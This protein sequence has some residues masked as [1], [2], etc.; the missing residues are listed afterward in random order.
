MSLKTN[1]QNS[2]SF[3]K[4]CVFFVT[5]TI[6]FLA[7]KLELPQMDVHD[8]LQLRERRDLEKSKDKESVNVFS[9]DIVS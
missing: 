5:F 8:L 6:A 1:K 3:E 4:N 2:S 7:L 9:E